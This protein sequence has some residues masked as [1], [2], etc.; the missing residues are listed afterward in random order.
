M[1]NYKRSSIL[2]SILVFGLTGCGQQ[3]MEIRSPLE[4]DTYIRNNIEE[5]EWNT[6]SQ[7]I[8]SESNI[9]KEDFNQL[10]T[11]LDNNPETRYI[12]N[13]DEFFRMTQDGELLYYLNWGDN[14]TNDYELQSLEFPEYYY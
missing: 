12:L 9:T 14:N 6:F 2:L 10:K 1:F 5:M 13:E 3:A 7:L 8:S 11:L 4:G